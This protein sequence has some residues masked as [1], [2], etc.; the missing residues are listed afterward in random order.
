V[1]VTAATVGAFGIQSHIGNDGHIQAAQHQEWRKF[2]E[3]AVAMGYR[4]LITELDVNDKDLPGA[5]TARDAQAAAV[6]REYLDVMLS[7][8]GLDQV[9]CWGMVD[10]YSWL[11]NFSPRQDKMP[12]RPCRPSRV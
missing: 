2:V 9:L 6:V 12:Q 10:K 1:A 11:Q 5:I 3:Q 8:R 7:Y 4:L